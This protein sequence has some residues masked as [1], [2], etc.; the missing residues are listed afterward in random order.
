[1]TKNHLSH[2]IHVAVGGQLT[3]IKFP[4]MSLKLWLKVKLLG[5]QFHDV[6]INPT[7]LIFRIPNHGAV[8]QRGAVCAQGVH[9][10]C[11]LTRG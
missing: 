4:T 11:S 7:R 2:L 1:M 3:Y 10:K 6:W 8:K 5:Y 9:N